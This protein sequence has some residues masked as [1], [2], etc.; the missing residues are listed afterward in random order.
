MD[1]S[2]TTTST[3][4]TT[5]PVARPASPWPGSTYRD[6]HRWQLETTA[7]LDD[8]RARLSALAAELEAAAGAGWRL[9]LPMRDGDLVA[10]RPSRRARARG[11]APVADPAGAVAPPVLH[12]WRL[13]VVDEAPD[14]AAGLDPADVPRSPV[15]AWRG[16]RL[17][18]LAGAA[19]APGELAELHRQVAPTG[20]PREVWC[21]AR[22][23]VGPGLDLVAA[24]SRLRG[25]AARDGRLV[26][27]RE[28]LT[29]Q[30][31]ADGADGLRQAA[32]A[33]RRLATTVDAVAAAGG[34]LVGADDGL[35]VVAYDEDRA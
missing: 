26:R 27:T 10:T 25:H 24:G 17:E 13:R 29:F 30:H 5:P 14:G 33:Y 7:S 18:L 31:A 23:R 9:E 34:R 8:A 3:T 2:P 19:M 21:V 11:A 15:V 4:S 16:D 6:R 20:L 35:L 28:A 12:G 32:A 22:A 1:S